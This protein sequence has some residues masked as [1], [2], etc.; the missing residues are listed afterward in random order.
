VGV[1]D[2]GELERELDE[3]GGN[4]GVGVRVNAKTPEK[5]IGPQINT[6]IHR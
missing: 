4:G 6:D 5:Y 2:G 3:K 1:V